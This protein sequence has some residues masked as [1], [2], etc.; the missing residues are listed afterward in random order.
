MFFSPKSFTEHA[1]KKFSLAKS[2]TETRMQKK[3]AT[4]QKTFSR[5]LNWK[6]HFN[7]LSLLLLLTSLTLE[8]TAIF[9][10][11]SNILNQMPKSCARSA[12]GLLVSQIS[13]FES[14]RIS[15][16]LFAR[17]KNGA[18]GKAATKMVI[19]PNWITK[20]RIKIR[21]RI[22]SINLFKDQF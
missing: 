2:K 15:K 9:A 1:Q 16:M 21:I 7:N 11:A 12:I 4:M 18:N 13:L 19:K 17:A 10:T 8:M 14:I 6:Q 22:N 3:L 20:K 5:K